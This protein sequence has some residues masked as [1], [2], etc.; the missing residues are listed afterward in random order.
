MIADVVLDGVR[1]FV[2]RGAIPGAVVGVL[3][4]GEISLAN[5]GALSTDTVVRASSNTKPLIAALTLAMADDGVLA[6]DDPVER[7]LPELA[8]RRV[9]RHLDAALDDTVPANRLV[10]ID[11]LLT[12]RLGFGFAFEAPCRAVQAADEA[13][14]GMGPPDPSMPLTPDKWIAR[15]AQLPL[16]EQPG[17]VWRYEMSY[18][19]LGVL[20]ARAAA[21][22]LD[23]LLQE[24]LLDPLGLSNTGFVAPPGRLPPCYAAAE[25]GLV[26]FDDAVDSRW[27]RPPSF[28]DARNGVVSTAADLLGFAGMLLDGGR[29]V[30]SG[31]AVTAM[32]TDQLTAAQ[33]R[34]TT[35]AAF[36]DGMGWGYGV[37]VSAPVR[38]YGW[39]GGLGTLWYSWPDYHGAAVLLTQVLPPTPDLVS[40]FA[41]AAQEALSATTPD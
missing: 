25:S 29:G 27:S 23:R 40:A 17:E 35:A 26:L 20:L 34:S 36:L 14:L 19:V 4:H 2:D 5:A 28:P 12:M 3:Q 6:L 7:F 13:G 37:Q 31:D 33:R 15:F 22:P 21:M 9:L 39:G 18:A 30:L 8:G 41:D 32:T 10:T 11:D 16:L 1:G 38:R 24:R